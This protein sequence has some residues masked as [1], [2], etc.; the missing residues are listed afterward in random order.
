MPQVFRKFKKP[1]FSPLLVILTG[2]FLSFLVLTLPIL[3]NIPAHP[4]EYQ[5]Y[6]NAFRIMGGKELHNYLHVAVTEYILTGFLAIVNLIT[7][8]GVNFPQGD[9]SAV[10]FFY[11]KVF[12]FIF[13][14]FTFILGCL[15]VQKGEKEIRLRTIFFA[16]FYFSSLG[17]FE[18]FTRVNSDFMALFL[19]L[20]FYYLSFILHRRRSPLYYF[21]LINLLFLFLLSFSNLKSLYLALPVFILNTVAPLLWYKG[22]EVNE[23]VAHWF[24]ALLANATFIINF[25]FVLVLSF[26]NFDKFIYLAIPVL[27]L[28][29]L[30]PFLWLYKNTKK[31]KL[32]YLNAYKL[33]IYGLGLLGGVVLLWY[34]FMP[35]PFNY[36]NFWYGIKHTTVWSSIIDV[37]YPDQS[38]NSWLFYL[39]DT[40]VEY[41]GLPQ[42]LVFLIIFVLGRVYLGKEFLGELLGKF[43]NQLDLSHFKEGNLFAVSE[44]LLLLSFIAF[45]LGV[46]SRV[47]HWSRWS[48]P[49]GFILM[50]LLSSILEQIVP[51]L[52]ARLKVS[53]PALWAGV[54]VLVLAFV[55]PRIFLT[56]DLAN[57]DY[58]NWEGHKKTYADV[59]ELVKELSIPQSEA[60]TSIAWF[61]GLTHNVGNASLEAFWEQPQY[62]N[63]KYLLWPHWNGGIL[64]TQNNVSKATHNQ[65]AFVDKYAQSI[66]Y[67]FPNILSY[68]T[69]YTKLF[70]WTYLGLT[71]SGELESIIE[72]QYAV[73]KMNPLVKPVQ[74]TYTINFDDMVHY[75][76]PKSTIFSLNN[77]PDGYMFPPCYSNPAVAFIATAK[78]V[79]IDPATGS[80]TAGMHCHGVRFRLALKGVYFI[81]IDGLPPD[82]DMTQKVYSAYGY[83]FDP[84]N[85]VITFVAPQTYV[86]AEFG[87]AVNESKIPQLKYTIYYES[88]PD[89][90]RP[91]K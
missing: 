84:V 43:K 23:E 10:T 8:S 30:N 69:H 32:P 73:I 83:N 6:Y 50:V 7:T 44:F 76:S 45:Y 37:D 35:R 82:I 80:R 40:V 1:E 42:L 39:Y 24:Q 15:I 52:R 85:K 86:T 62:K 36:R 34:L 60:T 74:L 21:F 2:I 89:N 47:V 71:Y 61:T 53:K 66:T 26:T 59:D 49:L 75:Y 19:F 22:E 13:Y 20:N 65:R 88:L 25:I 46:S 67:R 51:P 63:L 78:E 17:I 64:Y 11:G 5:F 55:L 16:L 18:R 72:P 70:A 12:S 33:M 87:V 77:L 3:I 54:S 91:N 41:L 90:L 48:L 81:K 38:H 79:P 31:L 68:Y 57:D 56:L 4:D 28:N 9:P 58:P 14:V 29:T 27:V